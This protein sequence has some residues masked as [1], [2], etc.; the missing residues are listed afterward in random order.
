MKTLK[1]IFLTLFL[2]ISCLGHGATA[3]P[4][5]KV[6]DPD[7]SSKGFV[8]P[9]LR[10]DDPDIGT[11]V[12]IAKSAGL[13]NLFEGTGPFTAFI[14]SNDAFKHVGDKQIEEWMKPANRDQLTVL[15]LYHI[16]PGRYTDKNLK[17]RELGSLNGKKLNITVSDNGNISV[18]DAKVVKKNITGPNGEIYVIDKVL[19]P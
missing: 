13:L 9:K 7:I 18:N 19:T 3:V 6:P 15:I 8:N 12:K 11:F 2:S 5:T 16:I 1:T 17:T 10:E 4:T 14:P